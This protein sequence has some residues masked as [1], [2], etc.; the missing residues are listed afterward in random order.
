MPNVVKERINESTAIEYVIFI[1]I[2]VDIEN[3]NASK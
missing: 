2:A 1:N 3:R